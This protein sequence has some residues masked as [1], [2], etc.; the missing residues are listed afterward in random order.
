MGTN[1]KFFNKN[2]VGSGCTFTLTSALSALARSLYDR[3]RR[4]KLVSVGSND[5][6]DEDWVIEFGSSVTFDRILIDNH[7]IKSGYIK[8]WNGS[9]YVDFTSA[10]SWSANATTTNYYELSSVTTTKI[11]IHMVTTMTVN[12]EKRVGGLFVMNQLGELEKNP[13]ALNDVD[14]KEASQKNKTSN[15]GS[16]YIF[17]GKKFTCKLVFGNASVTDVALFETLKNRSSSFFVYIG[18]GNTSNVDIGLR[19][20]DIFY[21][22][23]TSSFNPNLKNQN[24]LNIG[25]KLEVVLEEV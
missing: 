11:K 19:V 1:I 20:H 10:I 25:Q 5:T 18:S 12:D 21:V 13:T 22:N 8:Y 4:T 2:L 24:V 23:Y 6:T 15:G 9:S 14:F 17:F 7:N 3:D 16:L